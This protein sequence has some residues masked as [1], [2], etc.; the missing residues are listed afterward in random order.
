MANYN[1]PTEGTYCDI[2]IDEITFSE[3]WSDEVTPLKHNAGMPI[4]V[5]QTATGYALQD[6]FG[7]TSGMI[8]AGCS[9]IEAIIVSAD[10]V[11]ERSGA[12]DDQDWIEYL[13]QKYLG[14]EAP[15]ST[16]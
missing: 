4:I 11:E 14:C 7:R 12:G 13:Y 9:E 15:A 3:K 8:N 5:R 2:N 1:D 6:G 16:N 10:D